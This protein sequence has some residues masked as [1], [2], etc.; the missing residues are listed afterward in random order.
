MQLTPLRVPKILAFLKAGISQTLSRSSGGGATDGQPVR[1]PGR[2]GGTPFLD[3]MRRIAHP[4]GALCPSV[5]PV[6]VVQGVV[7]RPVVRSARGAGVVRR[8]VVRSAR[9]AGVG[10]RRVVRMA[11][12]AGRDPRWAWCPIDARC[13]AR[14]PRWAWCP[15]D[16]RCAARDPS[17]G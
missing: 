13:A 16:A 10:R 12:Y 17:G 8:P 9:G 11:R 14:D 5:V 2:V 1:R 15:I 4:E 3:M 7:R 6:P